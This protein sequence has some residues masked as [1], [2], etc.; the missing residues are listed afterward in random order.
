MFHMD[1]MGKH[2]TTQIDPVSIYINKKLRENHVKDTILIQHIKYVGTLEQD[3]VTDILMES[4]N[5]TI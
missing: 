4:H 5:I 3:N 1:K 2:F